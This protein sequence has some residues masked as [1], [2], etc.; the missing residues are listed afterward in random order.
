MAKGCVP[1]DPIARL[2]CAAVSR[3]WRRSE[4]SWMPA[5]TVLLHGRVA[6]SST[7]SMSSGLISPAG[8]S[9]SSDS[10]ALTRS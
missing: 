4:R 9:S 6:I 3:T 5:S 7:D 2:R 1:A 8:A 10:I